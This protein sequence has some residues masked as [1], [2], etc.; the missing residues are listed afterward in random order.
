[1][2]RFTPIIL[3]LVWGY[4]MFRFSAWNQAKQLDQQSAVLA[5]PVLLAIIANLAQALDL[6]KIKVLIHEV[7]AVNA[8]AAHDGR[9]F[10]TRGMYEKFQ[11]GEI[12]GDELASV[13]AHE[14]GHVALGHS[15][16]RMID[17][18]GQNALRTAL[19]TIASRFVPII[20]PW[21]VNQGISLLTA[22]LSR[23]DEFEADAYASALMIKS[24]FGIA[25]Q[26]SLFK[27]LDHLTG[28]RGA[29]MPAWFLTHPH[30]EERIKAI[31]KNALKWQ[32]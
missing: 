24:G 25:P 29:T 19:A 5:D 30:S 7:T 27:K 26:V 10:I 13:V 31:E 28:A 20:G 15:K 8:L 16:R 23:V 18:S 21:I 11:S 9:V 3:A 2:L 6:P 32:T 17:F 1:M 4:L 14:L 12:S 22:K